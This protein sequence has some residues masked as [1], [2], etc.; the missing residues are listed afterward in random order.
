MSD[1]GNPVAGHTPDKLDR[2]PGETSDEHEMRLHRDFGIRIPDKS[3]FPLDGV[4]VA[5]MPPDMTLE[6]L[7]HIRDL[8]SQL[9]ANQARP[10]VNLTNISQTLGDDP[11]KLWARLAGARGFSVPDEATDQEPAPAPAPEQDA[12]V[13]SETVLAGDSDIGVGVSRSDDLNRVSIRLKDRTAHLTVAAAFTLAAQIKRTAHAVEEGWVAP[14][15][16]G[17]DL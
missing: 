8:L 17:D 12:W 1:H 7:T 11:A 4:P 5:P 14:G 10:A 3:D 15:A 13:I 16:E 9:V 2:R 6:L